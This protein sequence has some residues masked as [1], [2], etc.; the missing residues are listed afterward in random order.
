MREQI[1]QVA[2]LMKFWDE[3][4]RLIESERQQIRER[5]RFFQHSTT[6]SN[7]AVASAKG[8]GDFPSVGHGNSFVYVT[9]AQALIYQ[10]DS[11]S[12]LREIDSLSEPVID[13]LL[14]P[15]DEPSNSN[16]FDDSLSVLAGSPA[17]EVIEASDYRHIKTTESRRNSSVEKLFA[18][19]IR[20]ES[21]DFGNIGIQLRSAGELGAVHRLL[22]GGHE[23]S[24]ILVEGTLSLPLVAKPDVSLFYEHL[25]RLCC[26]EARQ[27]GIGFFLISKSHGIQSVEVVE[28]LARDQMVQVNGTVAE[29]WYLRLPVPTF[30][31]WETSITRSH[32]LPPP[33]AVSYLIR[34]HKTT[35]T[36]R[37]D[38]D[39]N[40]WETTIRGKTDDETAN[41]EQTIFESLDYTTHDQR[42]Y[43]YP[44]PVYAAATRSALTKT[45]RAT[46]RKQIIDAAV[47]AG[48]KRSQLREIFHSS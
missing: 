45:E 39:L 26:V 32:R 27:R 37:L 42:C 25:K 47:S 44:Y 4:P 29:H 15:E 36:M 19:M 7:L 33:G 40:Y 2:E 17:A 46:L 34:F 12:G 22:K 10:S 8:S 21:A 1:Q 16:A 28:E 14:I 11:V 5:I 31:H 6:Q 24:Y 3:K 38:M 13:V 43:G 48:M 20:P 30:D 18:S 9:T 23:I 41:N 35:E